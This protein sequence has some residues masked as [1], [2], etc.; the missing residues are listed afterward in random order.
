[1]SSDG[2]CSMPLLCETG[3]CA[4]ADVTAT[5]DRIAAD[6]RTFIKIDYLQIAAMLHEDD[7]TTESKRTGIL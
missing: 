4:H 3:G 6:T 5:S 1:M 7:Q 2:D